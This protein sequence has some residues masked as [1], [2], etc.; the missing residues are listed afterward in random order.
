M[1]RSQRASRAQLTATIHAPSATKQIA[2]Q[3]G[4]L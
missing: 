4:M 1:T 3:N 2:T